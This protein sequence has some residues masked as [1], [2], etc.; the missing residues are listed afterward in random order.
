M[1]SWLCSSRYGW[2]YLQRNAWGSPSAGVTEWVCPARIEPQGSHWLIYNSLVLFDLSPW[3]EKYL[4]RLTENAADLSQFD[5]RTMA[6][7]HSH[8]D[9]TIYGTLYRHRTV[10]HSYTIT[11]TKLTNL[12]LNVTLSIAAFLVKLN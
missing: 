10:A 8:R 5:R 11:T 3:L 2:H 9:T 7:R 12:N 6:C 1:T 4:A